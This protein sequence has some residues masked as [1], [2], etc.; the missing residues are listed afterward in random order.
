GQWHVQ[1]DLVYRTVGPFPAFTLG[2][3]LANAVAIEFE[4]GGHA[5]G[6]LQL[7]A[8][9]KDAVISSRHRIDVV[10]FGLAQAGGVE[11]YTQASLL[12]PN[13]QVVSDEA[14]HAERLEAP[15]LNISRRQAG[16]VGW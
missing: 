7:L 14:R 10:P 12:S 3:Q 5:L 16:T 2:H 15:V 11:A 13:G 8:R 6:H 4:T 9:I 1:G